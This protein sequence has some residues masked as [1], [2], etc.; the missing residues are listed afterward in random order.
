MDK[1]HCTTVTCNF[2]VILHKRKEKFKMKFYL[3]SVKDI[4]NILNHIKKS[5]YI[6]PLF[7]LKNKTVS[8]CC[9]QDYFLW[10]IEKFTVVEHL[11]VMDIMLYLLQYDGTA[12]ID[13]FHPK[14]STFQRALSFYGITKRA[15]H[16]IIKFVY[17]SKWSSPVQN[18]LVLFRTGLILMKFI[19]I[20]H[21]QKTGLLTFKGFSLFVK[22]L[23][24]HFYT[25]KELTKL[26]LICFFPK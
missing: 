12:V 16:Y 13:W 9:I 3:K 25:S 2:S 8:T 18:S 23:I 19:F 6:S 11:A 22:M 1:V 20:V 15:R 26:G 10:M 21:P 5:Y 4:Q 14:M 24:Y 17:F 7:S